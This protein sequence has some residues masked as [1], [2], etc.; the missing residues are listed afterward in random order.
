MFS[1]NYGKA[2]F[3]KFEQIKKVKEQHIHWHSPILGKEMDLL[4]F[5]ESGYPIIIFPT[6]MGSYTQNKDFHLVDS[7]SWFVENNLVKIFTPSSIDNDSWYNSNIHPADRARNHVLYDRFVMEEVVYPALRD[8]GH[9]KAA[10][11]G[12]SFGAY[13]ALN[14]GLRHPEITG[15]ILSMGGAFNIKDRVKGHYDDNVYFNN[16]PDYLPGLSDPRIGEIGMIFGTGTQDMCMDANI[17]ISKLLD[18]KG[19]SHILDVRDGAVHDWPVWREM[20]P[21]YVGMMIK[22]KINDK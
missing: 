13:H 2:L 17:Q 1:T 22:E 10:F 3:V 18:D 19:I 7:V 9:S 4:I 15:F 8:T 11:A 14:F 21:A 12:C 20:F 6:S 5:G 16:P